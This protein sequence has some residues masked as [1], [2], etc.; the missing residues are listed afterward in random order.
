MLTATTCA[1]GTTRPPLSVTVPTSA[2]WDA[3]CAQ[4]EVA[5]AQLRTNANAIRRSIIRLPLG[6]RSTSPPEIRPPRIGRC[7]LRAKRVP[8][9]AGDPIEVVDDLSI[10][11]R[12]LARE[13]RG[14]IDAA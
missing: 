7:S 12:H 1:P 9:R 4:A 8:L 2:V 10:Q 6:L 11:H 14:A 13:P 3:S 5:S